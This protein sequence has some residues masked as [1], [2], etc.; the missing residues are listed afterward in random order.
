M[1]TVA[2]AAVFFLLQLFEMTPNFIKRTTAK[3][4]DFMVL[5]KE[6]D[7]QLAVTDGEDHAFYD[8][9][10]KLE[11]IH[12]AVVLY[13]DNQPVACGAL[14]YYDPETAEI[15]RMFT[16][17]MF[18]GRGLAGEILT[19]LE[20]WARDLGYRRCILETGINQPEAIRLYNKSG[21]QRIPNYGQYAGMEK[22]F[23]FEKVLTNEI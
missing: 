10:N 21:Y 13:Q 16:R 23:C 19:N 14:K 22:S 20:S 9:F 4:S 17:K 12:H 2:I 11:S 18:R 8:Q 6:L 1:I 3:D 15:K 5:V 7:Q